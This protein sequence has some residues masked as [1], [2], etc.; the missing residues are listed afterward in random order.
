MKL[1]SAHIRN[2]KLLRDL[3]LKFSVDPDKPLTVIRAENGSGKTSTL[4]ALRWAMYGNK[5]M[6]D[7]YVRLSPANWPD[8]QECSVLVTLDFLHTSVSYNQGRTI[9]S[10]REFTLKREV[11]E[12][13]EGDRPNRTADRVTIYEKTEQGAVAQLGGDSYLGTMLPKTMIDVFF[14]DGDSA[15]T[16]ISTRLPERTKQDKVKKAIKSLL[17]IEIL[18]SVDKRIVNTERKINRDIRK[19]TASSQLAEVVNK[20]EDQQEKKNKLDA[21]INELNIS[22]EELRSRRE[23]VDQKY[24]RALELGNHEELAH[25]KEQLAKD[26]EVVQKEEEDGKKA[27]QNLF[28]NP[29]LGWGLV[30]HA[31]RGGY[32]ILQDLHSRGVIPKAAVP[33]LQERLELKQCICGADLIEGTEAHSHITELINEQRNN[34]TNSDQ[35][36]SLYYSTQS[37]LKRVDTAN[38][39]DEDAREIRER[40]LTLKQRMD[41]IHEQKKDLE[42]KLNQIGVDGDGIAQ[43]RDQMRMYGENLGSKQEEKNRAE[44]ELIEIQKKLEQLEREKNELVRQEKRLNRFKYQKTAIEDLGKI[45]RGTLDEMN[46]QYVHRVSQR[47][48][49]LF[50]HMVGADPEQSSMFQRTEITPE[51]SIVVHA[52]DGRTLNLDSEVNGASQRALTFAFIWALTEISQVVA[53]RVIDTPLGMMSGSVKKRVLDI[54]SQSGGKEEIDRQVILFLTMSE[55]A[56]TEDLLDDRVGASMTLTKTD[57]HPIDLVHDPMAT[58]SEVRMCECNH[59]QC[60][61]QCQRYSAD[62]Y[63]LQ[64]RA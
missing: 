63:G 57:D 11:E 17:G 47:M 37:E 49:D 5:V 44:I 53:P 12:C 55:I 6:E 61:R 19:L 21:N 27:H 41:S 14:T 10:Q 22:I 26:L 9:T 13:P 58:E 33:V 24:T 1:I 30:G 8:G 15:M 20:I 34:D 45:V 16:F 52:K 32:E 38:S 23:T 50:L 40:R 54:V 59:R 48:N 56:Q 51:Y 42:E 31:M 64:Y 62:D 25:R 2:F 28:C 36:A 39:W 46:H 29:S 35:L 4:Q 43:L 60:C 3:E 18:E 7:P